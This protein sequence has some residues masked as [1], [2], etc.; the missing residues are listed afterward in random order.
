MRTTKI[1]GAE[2]RVTQT[3]NA[4]MTTFASP[5]Q[6]GTST[7]SLWR[8][9]MLTGQRGPEHTFDVEQVWHLLDGD[10]AVAVDPEGATEG[11]AEPRVI[12]LTAGDTVI[13]P[14]GVRRQVSTD[15]GAVFVVTGP[16]GAR[17]TPIAPDGQGSSVAPAWI[18]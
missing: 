8:V 2:A 9:E 18:L 7:L 13:L 11:S 6:G 3:P 4:S 15:G 16:A 1:T 10:A 5:S 14:A 17:A 12:R